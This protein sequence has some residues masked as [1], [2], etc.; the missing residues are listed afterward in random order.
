VSDVRAGTQLGQQAATN[1]DGGDL[2]PCSAPG[3]SDHVLDDAGRTPLILAANQCR[4]N[5]PV[6][7]LKKGAIMDAAA[8]GRSTV[9]HLA[10]QAGCSQVALIL[11]DKGCEMNPR[12]S[13]EWTPLTRAEQFNQKAIVKLRREHG[14]KE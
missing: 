2:H 6:Y 10:A 14:G 9:L 5:V 12:Y 1:Y 8:S 3:P 7:L 13:Q 4:T 11:T